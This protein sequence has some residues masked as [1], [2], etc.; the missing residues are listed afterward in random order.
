MPLII[1]FYLPATFKGCS[2]SCYHI[3]YLKLCEQWGTRYSFLLNHT[4]CFPLVLEPKT[5]RELKKKINLHLSKN[6]FCCSHY[7]G[8]FKKTVPV[9]TLKIWKAKTGLC[10]N[11]GLDAQCVRVCECVRA[12][13][14]SPEP[15]RRSSLSSLRHMRAHPPQSNVN[16]SAAPSLSHSL[17]QQSIYRTSTESACARACIWT[18]HAF[19]H[20][21]NYD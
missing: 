4:C 20:R 19:M 7:T 13:Q 15:H 8:S 2:M 10:Y 17:N 9:I 5:G 1:F 16:P 14:G 21:H 6:C 12:R 11:P 18:S 3:N